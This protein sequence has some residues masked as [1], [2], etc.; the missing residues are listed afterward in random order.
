MLSNYFLNEW[1]NESGTERKRDENTSKGDWE[2]KHLGLSDIQQLWLF[3]Y[4]L[5]C[6]L[7]MLGRWGKG[8]TV[9]FT[10]VFPVPKWVWNLVLLNKIIHEKPIIFLIRVLEGEWGRGD[11]WKANDWEFFKIDKRY[12]FL[13]LKNFYFILDY[14]WLTMLC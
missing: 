12:S 9:L 6:L 5:P 8:L 3:P 4:C 1:V 11:F 7:R 13:F 10:A 2:M 14:S